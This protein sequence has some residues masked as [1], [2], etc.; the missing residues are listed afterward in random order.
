M[1]PE[2]LKRFLGHTTNPH[3]QMAP[4]SLHVFQ[5][6]Y[7]SQLLKND[8]QILAAELIQGLETTY[9]FMDNKH[10]HYPGMLKVKG[11]LQWSGK[12]SQSIVYGEY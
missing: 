3:T 7:S 9:V 6:H 11:F 8:T 12:F 5:L 10:T 1:W 2:A 4:S